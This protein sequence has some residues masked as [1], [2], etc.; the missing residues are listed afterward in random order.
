MRIFCIATMNIFLAAYVYAAG[1]AK[2]VTVNSR[3]SRVTLYRTQAL[4]SREIDVPTGTG[5]MALV[6]NNLPGSIVADSL[7][8]SGSVKVR[9][10]RYLTELIPVKLP[11]DKI[12]ALEDK[13]EKLG[14]NRKDLAVKRALISKKQAYLEKIEQQYISKLGPVSTP[15]KGK[16]VKISGFDF[17]TIGKMTE[18]IFK[19]QSEITTRSLEFDSE[20]RKITASMLEIQNELKAIQHESTNKNQRRFKGKKMLRKAIIYI[21]GIKKKSSLSLSYLVQNANWD[22]AYNMFTT[23]EGTNL[24]LEY[25][26]HITQTTGEDWNGVKLILSTANP[27]INAENPIL[28]P[29]WVNLSAQ[30]RN[31]SYYKLS[32]L[33]SNLL[34]INSKAQ[35]RNISR[36]QGSLNEKKNFGY[37][38][39]LNQSAWQRQN[40]EFQVKK[41][42]IRHWNR[43]LRKMQ[44]WVAVEYKI[45][46]SV[47][48]ASRKDHQMVQILSK[49]MKSS[50]FYE[51]V[52]LF[53]SY[54]SRGIEVK[55]I[56]DQP[57][58]AGKYSAF[59]DGQFVGK[60]NIPVT[61]TGQ[62]LTLGFGFDSQLRCRRELVDKTQDKSWG[63]REEKYQYCLAID[64]YK[65]RPVKVRLLDRI[66]VTNNKELTISM[67]DG[68][69]QLS[70]NPEYIEQEK[71]K[72]ILRWDI[73]L[74]S[75]SSGAK[76]TKINYSFTMK[77][78][79][80]MKI[81]GMDSRINDQLRKDLVRYKSRRQR[82]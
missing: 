74:P 4:V 11:T 82:K 3:V 59:I 29:M 41:E 64:N 9:S 5:E 45:P 14:F 79:S 73:L 12:T 80:D 44:E 15:L 48:L 58:L 21:A 25:L 19:Q 33:S 47:T 61:A 53:S 42:V 13:L 6:V 16:E 52:P 63:S 28:V 46:D 62:T 20:E 2:E 65:H 66:P 40:L 36:I 76:A 69:K 32:K 27:N 31:N 18:M 8:A 35:M 60:G 77:F 23:S 26:A 7:F 72:G 56:I 24:N 38:V 67:V 78:D 70:K 43:E 39:S 71:P 68:K 81:S 57:L 30:Q 10:V 55:N 51:A 34:A 50:L 1:E 75:S 22:P 17:D 54:V 37:N 49:D